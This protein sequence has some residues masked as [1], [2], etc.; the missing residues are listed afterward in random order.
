MEAIQRFE[1]LKCW[2]ASRSLVKMIYDLSK[3]GLLARDFDLRSQMRRAGVGSMSNIAEGFGRFSTREFV[4]YLEMSQGSTQEVRSLTYVVEDQAY[5]PLEQINSLREASE[6]TKSLT[7]G[8][9]RYLNS[10]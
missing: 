7:L 9:A 5:L 4:R 1:D 10:R 6:K 3:H 2:Q 8:L